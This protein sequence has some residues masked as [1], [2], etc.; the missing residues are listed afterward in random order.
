MTGPLPPQQEG[1]ILSDRAAHGQRSVQL[2]AI[3]LGAAFMH[4]VPN[5][6]DYLVM[7]WM[8]VGL[9]GAVFL[10]LMLLE[11]RAHVQF[12]R[13]ARF[14][15]ILLIVSLVHQFEEH[16]VDL[17]G[18][19]YFLITYARTVIGDVGAASGFILTPLAIYRTNRLFVWLPFLAAVWGDPF[20]TTK[21]PSR[22]LKCRLIS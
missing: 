7:T 3:L 14:H 16:G 18:R 2:V 5:V 4:F 20:N 6:S 8:T 9:G 17:H 12:D 10:L 13:L 15:W 11:D 19:R 21:V 22:S 1:R